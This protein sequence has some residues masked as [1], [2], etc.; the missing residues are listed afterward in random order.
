MDIVIT[1]DR[2]PGRHAET[3]LRFALRSLRNI[4]HENVFI[5]GAMPAIPVKELSLIR[6]RSRYKTEAALFQ[7]MAM[8][9]DLTEDFIVMPDNCVILDPY[10][11]RE[12]AN[13]GNL[14]RRPEEME[15]MRG[16]I[17]YLL[18]KGCPTCIDYELDLPMVFNRT[19]VLE[20]V[21]DIGADSDMM[22]RTAYFNTYPRK[23]LRIGNPLIEVWTHHMDPLLSILALSDTAYE[24][25]QCRRWLSR[26][27][28]HHCRYEAEAVE[29]G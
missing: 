20:L 25:T 14:K 19:K 6:Q 9:E 21:E 17:A 5:A 15:R 16:A 23:H 12:F 11:V 26:A 1:T 2:E 29:A 8:R 7:S 22:F 24:H 3:R 4:P 13:V 10:M 27:L 28:P 18:H